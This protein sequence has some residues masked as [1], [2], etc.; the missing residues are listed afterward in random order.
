MNLPILYSFRR[1]PYAMRARTALIY[2]DISI[3]LREVALRAKPAA[4]LTASPKGSVPVLVLPDGRVIEQSWDI[5]LWALH[6]NDAQNWL[7]ENETKLQ[8]ALPLVLENDTTFKR[9]LDC[10][11]YPE[12]YP[13]QHQDFYRAQ[14]EVFMQKLET[15]LSNTAYLLGDT[16]SIADAALLPFVRQFTAV[17]AA[18]FA[19]SPYPKLRDWLDS[20]TRS[21]L[22][23]QVMQKFP[24]WL[25]SV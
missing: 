11:K 8:A 1:C 25:A 5:M 16:M 20:F 24:V 4:M 13:E 2:S 19:T 3:E 22:F 9:A 17:D 14:G 7:G 10:Y 21:E 15:R 6:H 18:W 23:A 12:R